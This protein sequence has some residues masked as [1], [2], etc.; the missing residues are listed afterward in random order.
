MKNIKLK[1]SFVALVFLALSCSD[2]EEP[3]PIATA[4]PAS[5]IINSGESTSIALTSTISGTSFSWTV[6]QTGIS[7]ASPGSGSTIAQTLT[8]TGA[9]A[10]TATYTITPAANGVMGNPISVVV[11]VNLLKTTYVANVKA[12]FTTS[13]T[14]CHVAGGTNPNKF[15]DYTTAKNK[16]SS[17]LDRVKRNPGE[18]GFMPRNGTK[19]PADKI[20]VLEKWVADGLLEK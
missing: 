18:S 14:P 20:A 4:T 12:I 9:A 19:L 17:I 8:V 16:I 6:Q 3:T 13:C 5:Q 7:G 11:T 2:D 1:I 15:D 10:G